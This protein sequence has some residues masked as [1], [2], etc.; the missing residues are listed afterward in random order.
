[1]DRQPVKSQTIKREDLQKNINEL[2]T[3]PGGGI[4]A[5]FT[6]A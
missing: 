1:M 2:K 4:Y 5:P 3:V 6:P